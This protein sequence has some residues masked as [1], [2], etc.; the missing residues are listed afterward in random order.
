MLRGPLKWIKSIRYYESWLERQS[1]CAILLSPQVMSAPR[2]THKRLN[3]YNVGRHLST[4][5][6]WSLTRFAYQISNGCER[7]EVCA[8]VEF[9]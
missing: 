2:E 1:E 7:G 4:R 6:N 8:I 9:S 3:G 5:K